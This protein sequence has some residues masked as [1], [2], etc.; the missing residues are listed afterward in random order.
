MPSPKICPAKKNP[1]NDRG[2]NYL[3]VVMMLMLFYQVFELIPAN[4]LLRRMDL[5]LHP[6]K[7]FLRPDPVNGIFHELTVSHHPLHILGYP[8][9]F[10]GACLHP[11]I[12]E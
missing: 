8:R 1:V 7:Y 5:G 6:G 3:L 9:L 10:F 11:H 4:G 12:A 2:F